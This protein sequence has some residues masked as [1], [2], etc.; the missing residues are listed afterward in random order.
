MKQ[1]VLLHGKDIRTP[2][3][4]RTSEPDRNAALDGRPVIRLIFKIRVV[5]HEVRSDKQFI[6]LK[7]KI[8]YNAGG[9]ENICPIL[10]CI[11]ILSA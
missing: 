5:F 6:W 8:E 4:I 7:K 3:G 9:S 11:K 2:A 1:P 10:N